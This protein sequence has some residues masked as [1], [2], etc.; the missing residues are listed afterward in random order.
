MLEIASQEGCPPEILALI[1]WYPDGPLSESERGAVEAHAASCRTCRDEIHALLGENEP[2]GSLV[3]AGAARA[4]ARA[5][6]RIDSQVSVRS[7]RETAR[8]AAAALRPATAARRRSLPQR[9][10]LA[11]SL[12]LA[13]AAGAA[14]TLVVVRLGGAA[15]YQTAAS[16]E[17][18]TATGPVLEMIPRDEV[19]VGELG[20]ALRKIDGELV[21]GP[22]GTLGRYKVRLP[23]GADAAAAAATLR[24]EGGGI[25]RYAET[26]RP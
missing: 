20:V 6:D 22:E 13:V 25:A 21:G 4:L 7:A 26:L 11:A 3:D 19:S 14:A 1:P 23:A 10:A 2:S 15:Q 16:P 8:A 5:L 17:A 9:L 18:K 12:V 24:A